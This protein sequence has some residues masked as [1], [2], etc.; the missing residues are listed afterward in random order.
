MRAFRLTKFGIE[1]LK[2]VDVDSPQPGPGEVLL[3]VRALSLNFRDLLVIQGAYNP[4]LRFP[5]IPISDGAGVVAAVGAGV[6]R[7]KPGDRVAGHFVSAWI[8]GPFR[9]EYAAS[10]LGTPGSG[11]A[12]EQ[13][14]LP[15]TAL[16]PIPPMFDFAEATTWPIAALTAWSS[17]VTEGHIAAGQTVLTLGTGGVSI[18]VLQFARALGADVIITSSSDEKLERAGDLGATHTINYRSEPAWHKRVLALTDG[19]GTDIVAEAG[20]IATLTH[21]L[22]A[23]RAGGTIAMFGALTGLQGEVNI[24]AVLMKRVRIAGILVDS[25]AAFE[26]MIQFMEQHTLRPVISNR[27]A[28]DDLPQALKHMQAGGHFGKIVVEL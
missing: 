26:D 23:V 13:V 22:S 12:A 17:L 15:E 28:F 20:G 25:R 3:D 27:F 2:L 4:K 1:H 7:W 11:L 10:T 24:A 16:V 9:G 18:F 21:S 6:S 19:L 5:A 8:D 14:V